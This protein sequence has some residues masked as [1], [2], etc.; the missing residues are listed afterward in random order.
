MEKIYLASRDQHCQILLGVLE[1]ARSRGLGVLRSQ[2][3]ETSLVFWPAKVPLALS[4]F[5]N[6]VTLQRRA[7]AA[8]TGTPRERADS[9]RGWWVLSERGSRILPGKI[10]MHI[11][12]GPDSVYKEVRTGPG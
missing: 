6:L 4:Q 8:H 10:P 3:G 1:S 11:G 5:L 9:G 7:Y 12:L 2:T